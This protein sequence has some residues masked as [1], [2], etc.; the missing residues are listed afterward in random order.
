[1]QVAREGS[2][3]FTLVVK[4]EHPD[5]AGLAVA[6]Q[7]EERLFGRLRGCAQSSE[8]LTELLRRPVAEERERGVQVLSRN[9]TRSRHV[10][11]L[12]L[13]PADEPVE[14]FVREPEG[15]KKA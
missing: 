9:D 3:A 13:L 12:A 14:D 2:G 7:R 1:M 8:D 5:A 4:R 11:E 10:P 15:E 6:T